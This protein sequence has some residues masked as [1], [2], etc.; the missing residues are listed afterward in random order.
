VSAHPFDSGGAENLNRLARRNIMRT[1]KSASAPSK[2]ISAIFNSATP[3]GLQLTEHEWEN[4]YRGT[5]AAFIKSGIIKPDW[6]PGQ[7]G[8]A[9]KRVRVAIVDGRM[10]VLPPRSLATDYQWSH[11]YICITRSTKGNLTVS[12]NCLEREVERREEIG[13]LERKKERIETVR[14]QIDKSIAELPM[15]PDEYLRGQLHTIRAFTSTIRISLAE[16][17][18]YSGGYGFN[19]DLKAEFD[20]IVERLNQMVSDTPISFNQ[21][22]KQ[23]EIACIKKKVLAGYGGLMDKDIEL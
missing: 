2:F 1:S 20:S 5:E 9:K 22:K 10:K 12:V 21:E 6:I 17:F 14:K 19:G 7:L 4:K 8:N 15:S 16:G 23:K 18:G 3:D 13:N 11:G